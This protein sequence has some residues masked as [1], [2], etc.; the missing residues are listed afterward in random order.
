MKPRGAPRR[1][2]AGQDG[3]RHRADDDPGDRV[4]FDDRGNLLEV[5]DRRIEDR[6]AR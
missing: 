3:D 4:P 6:L 2:D 5:V 1:Q